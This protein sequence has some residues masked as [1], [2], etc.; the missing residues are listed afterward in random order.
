M[1][2]S[3]TLSGDAMP[4][5]LRMIQFGFK[6]YVVDDLLKMRTALFKVV[7]LKIIDTTT[8]TSNFIHHYKTH[9]EGEAK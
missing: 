2:Y 9:K 1:F 7:S 6:D 4:A 3:E 5:R 8:T